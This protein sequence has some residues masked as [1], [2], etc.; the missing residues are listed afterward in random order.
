METIFSYT[1]YRKFLQDY[2]NDK[3]ANTAY[4]SFRFFSQKAGF[5]SPSWLKFIINGERNLSP[6][7][8]EK[9]I[10]ALGLKS[11]E[12]AYFKAL[13]LFNQAKSEKEKQ[14]HFNELLKIVPPSPFKQVD[15]GRY[16]YYSKWYHSAIRELV[17]LQGFKDDPHWIST[18]LKPSVSISEIKQ[19]L[20]LLKEMGFITCDETGKWI[21]A[22]PVI[23]SG[24]EV[25][26][27]AIRDFHRQMM[28]LG[29]ASI[30]EFPA[31]QREISALT[32]GLSE[33]CFNEMKARI[34][35]FEDELLEMA[36]KDKAQMTRVCQ[37]NFQFFPLI[38]D[39]EN[40]KNEN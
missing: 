6:E 18:I 33:E 39:Q 27:F 19:S 28:D 16:A 9:F 38:E 37:L 5:S 34:R 8:T 2:Y 31:R 21:Q 36:D 30:T 11:R 20:K 3:K 22:D 17:R 29:K 24:D 40:E 12:A 10:G 1:D 4:F 13:V 25:S 32:L 14:K 7:A 23:T 35:A 26:G 15:K